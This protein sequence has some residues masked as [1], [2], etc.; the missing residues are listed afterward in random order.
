MHRCLTFSQRRTRDAN[1]NFRC[2]REENEE[3]CC[4]SKTW[5]QRIHLSGMKISDDGD[6]GKVGKV[7]MTLSLTLFRSGM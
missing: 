4:A 7:H 2:W 5:I 1:G 6:S 3:M